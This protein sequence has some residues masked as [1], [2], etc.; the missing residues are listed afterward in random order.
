MCHSLTES[1][2]FLLSLHK[3]KECP[4]TDVLNW[5]KYINHSKMC[6]GII[7]VKVHSEW[8]CCYISFSK[9]IAFQTFK[10]GEGGSV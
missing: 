1:R 8:K 6:E 10:R 2:F 3:T 4:K 5:T 7:F 9:E